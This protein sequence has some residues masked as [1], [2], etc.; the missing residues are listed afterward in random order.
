[1]DAQ[2]F[3]A[4]AM[5]KLSLLGILKKLIEKK[6]KISGITKLLIFLKILKFLE[7]E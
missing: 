7:E 4:I 1:M 2:V 6:I 3:L 5:K